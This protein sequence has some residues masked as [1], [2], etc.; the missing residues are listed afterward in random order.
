MA[1]TSPEIS[2]TPVV[3][4]CG[5]MGSRMVDVT[6]D[7]IPKHLLEANGRTV[8]ERAIEPFLL[9]RMII[10]AVGHHGEQVEAFARARY[11][12]ER[13]LFSRESQPNGSLR[14]LSRALVQYDVSERFIF[15]NGDDVTPGFNVTAMMAGHEDSGAELTILG[16]T[17][18]PRVEDF[19]LTADAIMRAVDLRRTREVVKP[20]VPPVYYGVG[21]FVCEQSA[22]ETMEHA[23][24]IEAYMRAMIQGQRLGVHPVDLDY[25]N[26][27]RSEDLQYL[28]EAS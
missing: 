12:D 6:Q 4:L 26:V 16:T 10:L 27:N 3:I 2:D 22:L 9:S 13:L 18:T 14:A 21:T 5:G 11:G 20:L 1:Q 28:V 25:Y 15:A 7:T 23:Q 8:L 24:D 17:R 19:V